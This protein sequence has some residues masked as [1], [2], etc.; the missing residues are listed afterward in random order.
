MTLSTRIAIVEPTP[1]R[2]IFDECRRLLNGEHVPFDHEPSRWQDGVTSYCNRVGQ[3]LHALLRVD[4]GA[5][6]PLRPDPKYADDPNERRYYPPVDAWSIVVDFDTA[7]AYRNEYGGGCGD[8]HAYLV[9]QLGRWLTERG[10]TWYWCYE[11]DGTWHLGPA[12]LPILGDAERGR[13]PVA[14]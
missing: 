11:Y 6:A 3:G 10:L 9:Q 1:V 12:D 13:L 4:Y 7:Y 5:D 2:E 14:V 8:L